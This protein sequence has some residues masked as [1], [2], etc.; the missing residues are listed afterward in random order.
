MIAEAPAYNCGLKAEPQ[1]QW[2]SP[3]QGM[4]DQTS[5]TDN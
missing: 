3:G 1:V 2:Q 5:E 4:R